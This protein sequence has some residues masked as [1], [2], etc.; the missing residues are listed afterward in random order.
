MNYIPRYCLHD[1]L[2]RGAWDFIG[3][4]IKYRARNGGGH[5]ANIL[6]VLNQ[7]TRLVTMS[8][9]DFV[10]N[11]EDDESSANGIVSD[12]GVVGTVQDGNGHTP[13][14]LS[15]DAH[16]RFQSRTTSNESYLTFQPIPL[17][18]SQSLKDLVDVS[19][20]SNIKIQAYLRGR[21]THNEEASLPS[22]HHESAV[23]IGNGTDD[24][25]TIG[26]IFY[27]RNKFKVVGT[28]SI[29]T[30]ITS[31]RHGSSR[32]SGLTGLYA[33]LDAIESLEGASVRLIHTSPK[34][35]MTSTPSQL[36]SSIDQSDSSRIST[37]RTAQVL[38][39]VYLWQDKTDQDGKPSSN[40]TEDNSGLSIPIFWDK[41]QFRHA[42][43]KKRGTWQ[44]FYLRVTVI[45]MLKDGT[46]HAIS[47]SQSSAITVRGRS[48]Q[49]FPAHVSKTMKTSSTTGRGQQTVTGNQET[50]WSNGSV[51]FQSTDYNSTFDSIPNNLLFYDFSDLGIWNND[52]Q[53]QD[54]DEEAAELST[55]NGYLD[56]ENVVNTSTKDTHNINHSNSLLIPSSE[57]HLLPSVPN[58]GSIF[59]LPDSLSSLSANYSNP[60]NARDTP[61]SLFA[62]FPLNDGID[63]AGPSSLI[64]PG[65]PEN[66]GREITSSDKPNTIVEDESDFTDDE[67]RTYSYEYIPLSI[68]DWTVPVDA[69][70]VSV[71]T[72]P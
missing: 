15:F 33:E 70:Y 61:S 48:P 37:P 32:S 36:E 30:A 46:N 42:T 14:L 47:R 35:K 7:R 24:K 43:A 28:I 63:E 66:I 5:D 69:V 62:S 34:A 65:S 40:S 67:R 23:D 21:F 16:D 17:S 29:P 11:V 39:R 27:R 3:P 20:S 51:N 50:E 41:L 38:P 64:S 45:A 1:V 19:L 12:L 49:S 44:Y 13:D 25:D 56:R 57:T 4:C 71:K 54:G 53:W 2:L 72:Y 68:N 18:Q 10:E 8:E 52:L 9:L 6:A 55:L 60:Q 58:L 31:V 26:L 22:S 59:N